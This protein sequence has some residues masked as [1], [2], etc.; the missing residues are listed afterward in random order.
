LN[1][2]LDDLRNDVV[3]LERRALAFAPLSCNVRGALA[4][5]FGPQERKATESPICAHR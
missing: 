4:E 5:Y 3:E 1:R 2:G